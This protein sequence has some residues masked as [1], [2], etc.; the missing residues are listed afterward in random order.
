MQNPHPDRGGSIIKSDGKEPVVTIIDDRQF[1]I[2]TRPVRITYAIREHPWMTVPDMGFRHTRDAQAQRWLTLGRLEIG[3]WLVHQTAVCS[4]QPFPVTT[5]DTRH[6]ARTTRRQAPATPTSQPPALTT[7]I[8]RN[9]KTEL[10]FLVIS[11]LFAVG[12]QA[13]RAAA[14]CLCA[15]APP[16]SPSSKNSAF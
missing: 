6:L 15:T 16:A 2:L 12:N 5:R 8:A 7:E 10:P 14:T 13:C 3:G 9:S 11:V 4:R 1:P